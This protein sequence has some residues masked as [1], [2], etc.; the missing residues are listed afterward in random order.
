[1]YMAWWLDTF[2]VVSF[3]LLQYLFLGM[4]GRGEYSEG[5]SYVVDVFSS[6]ESGNCPER[7]LGHG[8]LRTE[9]LI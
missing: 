8:D 5:P 7:A 4:R 9:G 6:L 3:I 2:F 1:M